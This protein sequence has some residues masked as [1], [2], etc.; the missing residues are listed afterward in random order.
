MRA[1]TSTASAAARRMAP[2]A[3]CALVAHAALYG[4]W[5][6]AGAEHAYFRWYEPAVL[7]LAVAGA[8]MLAAALALAVLARRWP[9]L[10]R[11]PAAFAGAL[12]AGH[13]GQAAV[14]LVPWG[15][16]WLVGQETV[17]RSI[18]AGSLAPAVLDASAWL[19]ALGVLTACAYALDWLGYW[20]RRLVRGVLGRPGR[21]RAADGAVARAVAPAAVDRRRR[22]PLADRRAM[23]APPVA[24]AA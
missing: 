1:L 14:R 6:P 3:M 24:A 20:S 5:R 23:R 17:E 19:I 15:V 12:D 2:V 13:P 8:T 4:A 21:P 7:A 11:W 10:G 9:A 16:A 22:A 18:T